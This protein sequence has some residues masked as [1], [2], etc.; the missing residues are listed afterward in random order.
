M[1]ELKIELSDYGPYRMF[2]HFLRLMAVTQKSRKVAKHSIR[3]IIRKFDFQ[4]FHKRSFVKYHF[5][6]TLKSYTTN[7]N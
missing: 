5:C 6:E 2:G 3:P 7:D 4:L 1:K